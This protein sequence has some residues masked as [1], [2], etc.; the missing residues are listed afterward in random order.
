MSYSKKEDLALVIRDGSPIPEFPELHD[1]AYRAVRLYF[2]KQGV[3]DEQVA[4]IET[5]DDA[6]AQLRYAE[7]CKVMALHYQGMADPAMLER[8]AYF[9]QQYIVAMADVPVA[10]QSNVE[11]AAFSGGSIEFS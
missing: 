8:A 5:S 7:C 1:E 10:A 3:T 4:E 2:I 6:M 11:I 9:N